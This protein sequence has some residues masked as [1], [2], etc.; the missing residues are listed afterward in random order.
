M[1]KFIVDAQL[2]KSLS[3]FLKLRGFDSIHT[4]DLPEKNS[5]KDEQIVRLANKEKRVVISKDSDFLE[6]YLVRSEPEKLIIVKTGN[7]PNN[8]LLEIFDS[9]LD[10]LVLMISRSNLLEITQT[11]IAEHG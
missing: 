2:P 5:T 6:S 11:E 8:M 10:T 7:I 4:L 9:H 1:I 3:D